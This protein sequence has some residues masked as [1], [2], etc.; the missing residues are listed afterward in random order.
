M[1][2]VDKRTFGDNRAIR[3]EERVPDTRG[4]RR[5][6]S[7]LAASRGRDSPRPLA[8]GQYF[9]H[10][11]PNGLP[12]GEH[13][14]PPVTTRKHRSALPTGG[15]ISGIGAKPSEPEFG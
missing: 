9:K 6:P 2:G 13:A 5:R 12:T 11:S 14:G 4:H 10:I 7:T 1:P 3:A 8:G 15:P